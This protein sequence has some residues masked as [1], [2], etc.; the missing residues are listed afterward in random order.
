L[1]IQ[2]QEKNKE[3]AE[4]VEG[5]KKKLEEL[6]AK[7][8]SLLEENLKRREIGEKEMNQAHSRQLEV[9]MNRMRREI[10]DEKEMREKDKINKNTELA[11]TKERFAREKS[12]LEAKIQEITK[13]KG[14]EISAKCK[15]IVEL[16]AKME[17]AKRE[18]SSKLE[19]ELKS[20]QSRHE[21]EL[22][23]K[24]R[25]IEGITRQHGSEIE[26]LK[27]QHAFQVDT[28]MKQRISETEV[29]TKQ[30]ASELKSLKSLHEK[31]IEQLIQK[32]KRE[33]EEYR[34]KRD[35]E[36]LEKNKDLVGIKEK[37]SKDQAAYIEKLTAERSNLMKKHHDE[38][39]ELTAEKE[40]QIVK[41]RIRINELTDETTQLKVDFAQNLQT[42]ISELSR[43]HNETASNLKYQYQADMTTRKQNEAANLKRAKDRSM[44]EMQN[45]LKTWTSKE[46]LLVREK[47]I[48]EAKV[49]ETAKKLSET[50]SSHSSAVDSYK[51]EIESC[52]EQISR[53]QTLSSASTKEK[54]QEIVRKMKDIERLK[55]ENATRVSRLQREAE[56][57]K[58]NSPAIQELS[59]KLKKVTAEKEKVK[60]KLDKLQTELAQMRV[61]DMLKSQRLKDAANRISRMEESLKSSTTGHSSQLK[62]LS[63]K[64]AELR[65][66]NAA[67]KAKSEQNEQFFNRIKSEK[68]QLQQEYQNSGSQ[69][70]SLAS[71]IQEVQA[72]RNSLQA[73]VNRLQMERTVLQEKLNQYENNT[74]TVF[75]KYNELQ[76]EHAA[77]LIQM[78]AL[79]DQQLK[80][81]I[82]R[83]KLHNT[84]MDLKG[85]IR[86]FCRV[87]PF[88]GEENPSGCFRYP[89]NCDKKGIEVLNDNGIPSNFQFDRVFQP[90]DTQEDVF[91]EVHGVVQSALDGFSVCVF[92]YGQ[93]NSG[94]TYSME[95][96]NLVDHRRGL[97]PRSVEKIFQDIEIM[98]KRG[99]K[100]SMKV[101]F[102]EIYND[103]IRDLLNEKQRLQ[104]I[105]TPRAHVPDL[106]I[107]ECKTVKDVYPLLQ[108][109][110][111]ERATGSTAANCSSS[112]SHSVFCIRFKGNNDITGDEIQSELNL[113]DLAGSERLKK[114]K[115]EG[116]TLKETKCINLSLHYLKTVIKG[117]A[118][119][120]K[121]IRY[122]DS[123]LTHLLQPSLEGKGK[124]LMLLNLC[125]GKELSDES[126]Q[127]LQFGADAY[128]T[129][130]GVAK[131]N[132]RSSTR[133]QKE[134]SKKTA[135]RNSRL[136]SRIKKTN[137]KKQ[138]GY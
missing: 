25:E 58:K 10:Q 57:L 88:I 32:S 31:E 102:L 52:K 16:N 69:N 126:L 118:S 50:I 97:I 113:I 122:R 29:S 49:E 110:N 22:M 33:L 134:N 3:I 124:V 54:D 60:S 127:S 133:K 40:Q 46:E 86:V 92:A 28:L 137:K 47:K 73:D 87:R 123:K 125:P 105:S 30:H 24:Q 130:I 1:K 42:Q 27:K 67:F 71:Q 78:K 98:K 20:L 91:N 107:E 75:G 14:E 37:L 11:D 5:H 89:K 82:L 79:K 121:H 109:A 135:R 12:E 45:Q 26:A 96:E 34:L 112:R 8:K 128:N 115:A 114:S 43:K 85:N 66:T 21:Q 83:R 65:A 99:W 81:E 18:S 59:Q 61:E 94:K 6:E 74:Q 95:G 63:E 103:K 17:S 19:N 9:T 4:L 131:K 93:T 23:L 7:R 76:K 84:I 129:V 41:K 116:A 38:L 111:K 15:E 53:L 72:Q 36:L 56:E 80:D 51:K 48:L 39:R 90:N 119:K 120:Q 136:D 117:I 2:N 108:R 13:K 101:S 106:T 104:I 132:K 70:R 62:D 64:N 68:S 77:L 35:S 44:E 138:R 100:Y 55:S